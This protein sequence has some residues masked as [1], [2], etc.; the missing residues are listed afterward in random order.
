MCGLLFDLNCPLYL[1]QLTLELAAHPPELLVWDNFFERRIATI[2]VL[3]VKFLV[4][5][6][7]VC[8]FLWQRMVLGFDVLF[9]RHESFVFHVSSLMAVRIVV[10]LGCCY[11]DC[12]IDSLLGAGSWSLTYFRR[13]FRALRL[14][15]IPAA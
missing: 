4:L 5:I 10:F 14:F 3:Y 7:S 8:M 11:T 15:A 12:F 2:I 6:I 1:L 13:A 9:I